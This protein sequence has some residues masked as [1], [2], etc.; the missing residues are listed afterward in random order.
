MT[1]L[2]L[3]KFAINTTSIVRRDPLFVAIVKSVSIFSAAFENKLCV[4]L[5]LP[6]ECILLM[7][8][9]CPTSCPAITLRYISSISRWSGPNILNTI[10]DIEVEK[11]GSRMPGIS[12][13]D[14]GTLY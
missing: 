1:A 8:W 10:G 4:S 12:H 9:L 5:L 7:T 2:K 11:T 14:K 13:L 3:E 6:E